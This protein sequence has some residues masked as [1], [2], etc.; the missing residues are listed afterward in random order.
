MMITKDFKEKYP[1]RKINGKLQSDKAYE[2][3]LKTKA[4]SAVY[5]NW[6]KKQKK[7]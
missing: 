6:K 5:E 7:K 3:M 4:K 1:R 2:R